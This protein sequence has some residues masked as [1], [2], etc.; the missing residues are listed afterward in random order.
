MFTAE[1]LLHKYNPSTLLDSGET[2]PSHSSDSNLGESLPG[3]TDDHMKDDDS[4]QTVISYYVLLVCFT[5]LAAIGFYNLVIATQ[6][7]KLSKLVLTFYVASEIV[8]I[9]RL[10]LFMDPFIDWSTVTYIVILVS[11]PSYLYLTVGLC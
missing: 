2:A 8:I 7:R 11:M 9:F 10:L 3:E 4:P 6:I 1:S 5:I